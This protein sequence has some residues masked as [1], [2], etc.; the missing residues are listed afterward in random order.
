[1]RAID[2]AAAERGVPGRV[3]M[4]NAGQAVTRAVLDIA[5]DMHG[6][7]TVVV[8][9]GKG[10]NGGDGLVVARH[11][12]NRGYDVTVCLLCQGSDLR[13]DAAE[14]LAAAVA[15]GVD[16]AEGWGA[17]EIAEALAGA[18]I[19]VD[20]VLGTGIKGEVEGIAREAIEAINDADAAVV[21]V[22]IPS[23]VDADTGALGG[24]AIWADATV[25]FGLPK[26]GTVIYPG[27]GRCGDLM[28]A[29]ISLPADLLADPGLK[30]NLVTADL[31]QEC[32]PQR[33]PDMHKGDAG[34]VLVVAGSR[35]YTGAAT[36][37]VHG[38]MR[39]GAGLVY[40]AAPQAVVEVLAAHHAEAI[41]LQMPETE[42]G[43]LSAEAAP[44][45]LDMARQC[46]AVAL[47]PGLGHDEGTRELVARL[48]AEIGA[49]LVVDADGLNCL[50]GQTD[51]LVGRSAPTVITPHPGEMAS[52]LG[53]DAAAVQADRLGAAREAAARF[54]A[55]TVL[56]GAG[57][58]I[59]RP[60]GE[61]WVNV[62]GNH[63]LA[64]GGTGDVLTGI[65][66]AFV[67]GG[68]GIDEAAIAGV[69]YHGLAG[70][71]AAQGGDPRSV[72]A[73][74]VADSLGRAMASE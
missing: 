40:L 71:V 19:V 1:M 58:V 25:T 70:E 2:R 41:S 43:G 37:T 60:D 62:T 42:T 13:G 47:G 31:A 49:P 34:R 20:A 51:A 32:L 52:L 48:V 59:A 17:D 73:S 12:R 29:D 61:A 33:W 36:L 44:E 3:L 56:K 50:A 15:Y 35:R 4:E 18:D 45:I 23:G 9:A 63:G 72:V 11:L 8:V 69:Y 67:A 64:S 27:G 16:V 28:V 7:P 68:A 26:V 65:I 22:D 55:V 14:N 6:S 38:A 30:T 57:T 10:N 54:G 66:A 46:E 24:A 5:K 53:T 39:A 21:A 74:D